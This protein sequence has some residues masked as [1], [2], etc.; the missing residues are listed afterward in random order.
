MSDS[1]PQTEQQFTDFDELFHYF[2]DE[3]FTKSSKIK[4]PDKSDL[5]ELYIKEV[6]DIYNNFQYLK[7][8]IYP[9]ISLNFLQYIKECMSIGPFGIN[10]HS[11]IF[12]TTDN[13]RESYIYTPP[14]IIRNSWINFK[15]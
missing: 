13:G 8:D 7:S 9:D 5:L 4:Q 2:K 3:V 15:I 14:E 12:Y 6:N 1:L 10:K 11:P